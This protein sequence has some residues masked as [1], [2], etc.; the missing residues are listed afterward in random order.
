MMTFGKPGRPPEDRLTRQ[1]EIYEAVTP[2]L[3]TLGVRQLSM[4]QAA[5][6]ACLSLG[7]LC[8]YFPTKRELA[9]YGLDITA[10]TRLCDEYHER[11]RSVRA[12]GVRGYSDCYVEHSVRMMG[13]MRPAVQAALDLRANNFRA[14]LDSGLNAHIAE[15]LDALRLLSP[16]ADEESLEGLARGVR[17]VMYGALFDRIFD[18]DELQEQLR[19]LLAGYLSHVEQLQPATI[20]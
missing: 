16:Q 2:L 18:P 6:A 7:S 15:L 8:Q 4:Q 19:A 20:G 17:R 11:I 5:K 9:L 14:A 3:L 12:L 13:F 10:Q 1:C